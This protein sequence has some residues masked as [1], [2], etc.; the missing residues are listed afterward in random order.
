VLLVCLFLLWVFGRLEAT[1]ATAALMMTIVLAFP[2]ALGAAAAR[3][4]L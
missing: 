1:S 2:G 3:L 4:I